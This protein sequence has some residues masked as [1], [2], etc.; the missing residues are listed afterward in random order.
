MA[1]PDEESALSCGG[2]TGKQI[3]CALQCPLTSGTTIACFDTVILT[4]SSTIGR[5]PTHTT[6]MQQAM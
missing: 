6:Q 5:R 1:G 4:P 3:V 2:S